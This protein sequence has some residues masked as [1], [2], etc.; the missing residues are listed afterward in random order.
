MN[1][2]VAYAARACGRNR[3]AAELARK[4]MLAQRRYD[5][6]ACEFRV[7]G[8]FGVGQALPEKHA[9]GTT[10]A[11]VGD[12]E[13]RDESIVCEQIFE[14]MCGLAFEAHVGL[15]LE[16][17]EFEQA[18]ATQTRERTPVAAHGGTKMSS[19]EIDHDV[20]YSVDG[21][22]KARRSCGA[23]VNLAA[24]IDYIAKPKPGARR[25]GNIGGRR[26]GWNM[27][28]LEHARVVNVKW[29][30]ARYYG[31]IVFTR[32]AGRGLVG[33]SRFAWRAPE[34]PG[35]ARARAVDAGARRRPDY[36]HEPM[37]AC[38]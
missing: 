25:T 10:D 21:I 14:C 15:R 34:R 28:A 17:P 4:A 37:I 30:P 3:F 9:R 38:G 5:V 29:L 35:Q 27:R 12:Q 18:R 31:A 32:T 2:D 24:G 6:D 22:K 8:G 16:R 36:R 20:T 1:D 11:P 26:S 33:V 7:P 19:L 13:P 23:P